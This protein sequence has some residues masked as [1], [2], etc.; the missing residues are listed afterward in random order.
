MLLD[1][2]RVELQM[3][4]QLEYATKLFFYI[5]GLSKRIWPKDSKENK[6]K[7]MED[8]VGRQLQ[9]I[10]QMAQNLAELKVAYTKALSAGQN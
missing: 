10:E 1:Q 8:K 6:L 4:F 9:S 2:N 3:P 7:T 5:S